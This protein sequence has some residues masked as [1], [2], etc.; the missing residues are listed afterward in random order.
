M[1]C[2]ALE[3]KRQTGHTQ[4]AMAVLFMAAWVQGGMVRSVQLAAN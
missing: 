3:N 2:L 4:V 1:R